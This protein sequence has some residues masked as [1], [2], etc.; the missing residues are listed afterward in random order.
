MFCERKESIIYLVRQRGD[1]SLPKYIFVPH[2]PFTLKITAFLKTSKTIYFGKY[3][4]L[5][6]HGCEKFN[7]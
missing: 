7:D 3:R 4:L 5:N 6:S 1:L 2:F